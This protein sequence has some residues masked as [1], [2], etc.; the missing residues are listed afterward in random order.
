MRY[1]ALFILGGIVG[2]LNADESK[3]IKL[4]QMG[5]GAPA[6]IAYWV[7][8]SPQKP[9]EKASAPIAAIAS[10]FISE[11]HAEESPAQTPVQT[12]GRWQQFVDGFTGKYTQT[13]QVAMNSPHPTHQ[14]SGTWT[15]AKNGAI[16]DGAYQAG[17]ETI[18]GIKYLLY[19]CRAEVEG[20]I[21]PGKIRNSFQGCDVTFG[22]KERQVATYQVLM[23]ANYRWAN[24]ING[25]IP[26]GAVLGG[27]DIPPVKEELFMCRAAVPGQSGLH[28]GKIRANFGGCSVG[29]GGDSTIVKQ[30]EVLVNNQL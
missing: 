25:A 21:H 2:W 29:W 15:D 19:I 14:I 24:S 30:Y 10:F 27:M 26:S 18:K 3:A 11:A 1:V 7:A 5:I 17:I 23:A 8:G 20:G 6:L 16:P 22:G 13:S 28:P 4:F 9:P 12:T